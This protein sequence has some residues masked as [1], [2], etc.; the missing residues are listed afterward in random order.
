MSGLLFLLIVGVFV[1]ESVFHS[2]KRVMFLLIV[3]FFVVGIAFR[4]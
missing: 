1:V 3:E 4:L 2:D